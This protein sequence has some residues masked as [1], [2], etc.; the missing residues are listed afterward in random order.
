VQAGK[1]ELK[2]SRFAGFRRSVNRKRLNKTDEKR[3]SK[4][5]QLKLFER[6]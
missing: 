1:K 5:G 2:C 4:G 6:F 3:P